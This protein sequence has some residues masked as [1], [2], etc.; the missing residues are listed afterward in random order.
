MPACNTISTKGIKPI[1]GP[2]SFNKKIEKVN[3]NTKADKIRTIKIGASGETAAQAVQNALK[4]AENKFISTLILAL[5]EYTGDKAVDSAIVSELTTQVS[6]STNHLISGHETIKSWTKNNK[7]VRLSVN[8]LPF[9]LME[10]EIIQDLLKRKLGFPKFAILIKNKKRSLKADLS[11]FNL[12]S[13]RFSKY[14]FDF[15]PNTILADYIKMI[16]KMKTTQLAEKI[17]IETGAKYLIIGNLTKGEI[18]K[19]NEAQTIQISLDI[20]IINTKKQQI[21]ASISEVQTGTGYSRITTEKSGLKKVL[22]LAFDKNKIEQ[23][24]YERWLDSL[25]HFEQ[26]LDEKF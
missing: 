4:Q 9:R 22:D 12:I 2:D 20:E 3:K 15:V 17:Y 8:G 21:L 11:A 25:A 19:T 6:Q 18:I 24:I 5:Y 7:T 23:Q 26:T 1:P 13:Q 14:G 16:G 10:N